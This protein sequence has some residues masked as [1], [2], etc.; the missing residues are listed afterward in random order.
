MV[1][2]TKGEDSLAGG[3]LVDKGVKTQ[4]R[5]PPGDQYW[6]HDCLMSADGPGFSPGHLGAYDLKTFK[7]G[8]FPSPKTK[9]GSREPLLLHPKVFGHRRS[10]LL[11]LCW[12]G[13]W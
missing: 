7:T 5:S 3:K 8:E 11:C 13:V 12:E 9:R 2:W 4:I 10:P 6:D 1:V